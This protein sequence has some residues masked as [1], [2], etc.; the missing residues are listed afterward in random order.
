M[1]TWDRNS[2][3]P[4]SGLWNSLKTAEQSHSNISVNP[5]NEKN[6]R[7]CYPATWPRPDLHQLCVYRQLAG[8]VR[9]TP[10]RC[11]Q[12]HWITDCHP[13]VNLTGISYWCFKAIKTLVSAPA[14]GHLI[15]A[16]R[17]FHVVDRLRSHQMGQFP[18]HCWLSVF[19]RPQ[20]ADSKWRC[21]PI[22]L[23]SVRRVRSPL[24]TGVSNK[25][26]ILEACAH[27][28]PLVVCTLLL[29]F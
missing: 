29:F 7:D 16:K 6:K 14:A 10:L 8:D 25:F 20:I 9:I 4:S 15:S 2:N 12:K 27:R 18:N 19:S 1:L 28:S 23:H 24:G 17:I 22:Y 26:S 21:I 5:S 11:T 3:E 13:V